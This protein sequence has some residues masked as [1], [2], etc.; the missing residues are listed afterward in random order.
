MRAIIDFLFRNKY[1][2]EV[3]SSYK[4]ANGRFCKAFEVWKESC[5]TVISE[6]YQSKEFV[7]QNLKQIKQVIFGFKQQ[8]GYLKTTTR[9]SNG[10]F[11]SDI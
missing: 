8:T 6:D 11:Q 4:E 9:L 10:Y 3:L 5:P 7:H 2:K 1:Y